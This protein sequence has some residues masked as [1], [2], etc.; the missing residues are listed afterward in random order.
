MMLA[1]L[2]GALHGLVRA[3]SRVVGRCQHSAVGGYMYDGATKNDAP[4]WADALR[5]AIPEPMEQPT[6][7]SVALAPL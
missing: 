2:D 7:D 3:Y 6:I 1:L 4:I 5:D